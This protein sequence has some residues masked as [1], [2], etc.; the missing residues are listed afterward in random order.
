MVLMVMMHELGHFITAKLSGMKVTEYFF[1]F[2]PRLWSVK[3]G[4]TTY[5]IKLLPLGGYVKIV[6]MTNLDEV[7]AEDEARAYRSK[8]FHSRFAVGV[9]GSTMHGVMAFIMLW[10][11]VVFIGV[12]G[13][14]GAQINSF[15]PV[16]RGVDPAQSAGLRPGD[17]ILSADGHKVVNFVQLAKIIESNAGHRVKLLVKQSGATKTLVVTP[18]A[19][20]VNG[21]EEGR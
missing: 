20:R 3:R 5:G 6:G 15:A 21:R 12:P 13:N 2:G 10:V 8:P 4:E 18:A 17:V 11:L 14:H 9:A 7:P 19:V 16:S 1:G